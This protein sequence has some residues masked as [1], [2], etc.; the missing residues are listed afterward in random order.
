MDALKVAADEA[1][2]SLRGEH[3]LAAHAANAAAHAASG[4][5]PGSVAAKYAAHFARLARGDATGEER[6]WQANRL[7]Q[8]LNG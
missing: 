8:I 6:V 3:P 4:Y 7:L 1:A 2:D 5:E